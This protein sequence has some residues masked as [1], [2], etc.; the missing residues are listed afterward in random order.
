MRNVCGTAVVPSAQP[1][2]PGTRDQ[3][4]T[5]ISDSPW[6]GELWAVGRRGILHL[7]EPKSAL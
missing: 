2:A 4:E 7:V 1:A 5:T 3:A 6:Q